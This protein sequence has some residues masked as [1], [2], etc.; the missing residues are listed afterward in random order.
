MTKKELIQEIKNLISLDGDEYTD[1]EIIDKIV[2][3][4]NKEEN[5]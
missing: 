4:I 3:L 1:G 2:E 5:L